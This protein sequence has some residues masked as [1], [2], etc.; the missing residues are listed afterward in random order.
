MIVNLQKEVEGLVDNP[1]ATFLVP[2]KLY[3]QTNIAILKAL[4]NVT[5]LPGIYVTVNKPYATLVNS[6]KK[7]GVD[8]SN[9]FFIDLVTK[10]TEERPRSVDNCLFMEGPESLT[11]LSIALGEAVNSIPGDKFI[12]LDTLSTLLIYNKAKTVTKFAHFLTSK[13]RGWGIKGIII[14]LSKETKSE[15]QAELAQ[16]SDKIVDLGE[17]DG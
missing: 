4:V 14:S 13:I 12:F 15:L 2:N 5:K 9:L 6:F 7:N 17:N 1:I 16:F 11:D 3:A 8:V 10:L